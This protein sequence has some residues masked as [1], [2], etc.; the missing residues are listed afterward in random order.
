MHYTPEFI[1]IA[2]PNGAGKTTT[3]SRFLNLGGAFAYINADEIYKGIA[4]G[5]IDSTSH[6]ISAGKMA[7]HL[8]HTYLNNKTSFVMETTLSGRLH[9]HLIEKAKQQGFLTHIFYVYLNSPE[10][11]IQ[12]VKQ[13]VQWGGHDI[14]QNDIIRRYTK[15]LDKLINVYIPMVD[16]VRIIDNSTHSGVP[17]TVYEKSATMENIQHGKTWNILQ[18]FKK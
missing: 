17:L 5:N 12:R 7:I 13:R 18:G 15:S 3:A 1:I 6:H 16:D 8:A 10:I 11:A 2:G 9:I 4:L 14:P